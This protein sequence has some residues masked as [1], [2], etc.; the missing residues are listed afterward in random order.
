MLCRVCVCHV[1]VMR[2]GSKTFHQQEQRGKHERFTV[3]GAAV[4][5]AHGV[6]EREARSH[7]MRCVIEIVMMS[8]NHWNQINQGLHG[9]VVRGDPIQSGRAAW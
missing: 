7:R 2:S 4:L 5:R 3:R 8:V 9:L 6:V 1:S